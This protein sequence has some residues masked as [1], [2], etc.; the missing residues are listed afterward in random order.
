MD[1]PTRWSDE[2]EETTQR[3]TSYVFGLSDDAPGFPLLLVVSPTADGWRAR[4]T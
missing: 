1:S 2:D 4:S 3:K